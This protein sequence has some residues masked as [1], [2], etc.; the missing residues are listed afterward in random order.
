MVSW[1]AVNMND[2]TINAHNGIELKEPIHMSIMFSQHIS[3]S[4]RGHLPSTIIF[5][6]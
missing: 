3:L 1:L 4:Y 6:Y 2:S 5:W